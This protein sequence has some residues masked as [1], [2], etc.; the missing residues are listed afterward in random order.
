ME[1]FF[2]ETRGRL[3]QDNAETYMCVL[4]LVPDEDVVVNDVIAFQIMCNILSHTLDRMY[5][6]VVRVFI[7]LVF[8]S[9]HRDITHIQPS[10][11]ETKGL[12]FR[13]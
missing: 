2:I 3:N 5:S 10:R 9:P 11:D 8:S 6:H 7:W 13:I 12:N 1:F 4:Q